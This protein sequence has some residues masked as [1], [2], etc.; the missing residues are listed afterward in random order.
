MHRAILGEGH[1]HPRWVMAPLA[2]QD[3]VCTPPPPPR[4][5]I[6]GRTLCREITGRLRHRRTALSPPPADPARS[7]ARDS[8]VSVANK[9]SGGCRLFPSRPQIGARGTGRS[10][11]N[12]PRRPRKCSRCIPPATRR[13]TRCAGSRRRRSPAAATTARRTGP[14]ICRSCDTA[15]VRS[16]R[17]RSAQSPNGAGTPPPW[18]KPRPRYSQLPSRVARRRW[19]HVT[20]PESSSR[21]SSTSLQIGL[22]LAAKYALRSSSVTPLYRAAFL[23]WVHRRRC[24]SIV[25]ECCSCAL[26]RDSRR[27]CQGGPATRLGWWD[28]DCCSRRR[29][30]AIGRRR[31]RRRSRRAG[32]APYELA[33]SPLVG[34]AL[35]SARPLL[36]PTGRVPRGGGGRPTSSATLDPRSKCWKVGME[37]TPHFCA[38]SSHTS[39]STLAKTVPACSAASLHATNVRGRRQWGRGVAVGAALTRRRAARWPCTGGTT[40]RKSPPA[41]SCSPRPAPRTPRP[42]PPRRPM[43]MPLP[44]ALPP[45]RALLR[46]PEARGRSRRSSSTRP[47]R[48]LRRPRPPP[49]RRPAPSHGLYPQ[50]GRPTPPPQLHPPPDDRSREP[51]C[52]WLVSGS[53]C[54]CPDRATCGPRDRS[55]PTDGVRRLFRGLGRRRRGGVV[56]ERCAGGAQREACSAPSGLRLRS[57]RAPLPRRGS[58]PARPSGRPAQP[59]TGGA[60]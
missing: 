57:P 30:R 15:C 24:V 14:S 60:G 56:V 6:T 28:H 59:R 27:E 23:L 12:R 8:T 34:A 38:V 39:T 26:G 4:P 5:S 50:P 54:R 32:V 40:P 58:S 21:S 47:R 16:A 20:T 17:I 55:F 48:A 25:H 46:C 43:R 7:A 29:G 53:S 9:P 1:P 42:P 33:Q 51:R 31:R 44:R 35:P 10:L 22:Q 13:G 49:R 18:H 52:D 19:A 36:R 37:F 2:S 41:R 45:P 11:C 3:D